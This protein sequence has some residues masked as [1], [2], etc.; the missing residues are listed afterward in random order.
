MPVLNRWGNGFLLAGGLVVFGVMAYT[1]M[2]GRPG[3]V[4]QLHGQPAYA[5]GVAVFLPERADWLDFR[6]GVEA[7]EK[8]GLVR[9][10]EDSGD[11]LELQTARQG[12]ALRLVWHG[13][14]G[15]RQAREELRRLLRSAVPPVAVVGSINTAL[16]AALAEELRHAAGDSSRAGQGAARAAPVLLVPWAT[17]TLVFDPQ[18]GPGPVGL[19]DIDPGR[20]FRFCFDNQRQAELLVRALAGLEPDSLPWRAFL[21]V[22]RDDPYSRDLAD[23]FRRAIEAVAPRAEIVEQAEAVTPRPRDDRLEAGERQWAASIARSAREAGAGAVTWV[24]LP[25]QSEPTKRLLAALRSQLELAPAA[26]E[27]PLRVLCGDSLGLQT[28][29]EL[30][31]HRSFPLWCVS[32]ASPPGP[33]RLPGAEA[34]GDAQVSAEVVAALAHVLDQ[35]GE[36]PADL[37]AAL[38]ALDLPAGD[39]A[40]YGRR[41]AFA[42]SGERLG[43]PIGHVLVNHPGRSF[44][45]AYARDPDGRWQAVAAIRPVPVAGSR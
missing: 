1:L 36:P 13:V 24:V 41:L 11:A 32:P 7:C 22:D 6:R 5:A 27:G 18:R 14:R 44:V 26:G 10:R 39:P 21:V 25:L 42:A 16:T 3:T 45:Q 30:A 19:L 35:P 8:R 31:G 23:G 4:R 43:E 12:R 15:V 38:A 29:L 28:I 34:A 17:S 2:I 40:A 33:A 37:R 20:T 9:I